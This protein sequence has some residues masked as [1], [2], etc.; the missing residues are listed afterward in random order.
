MYLR[1]DVHHCKINIEMQSYKEDE[2][3]KKE[4]FKRQKNSGL[5]NLL[6]ELKTDNS[7]LY[8]LTAINYFIIYFYFLW[9]QLA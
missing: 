2:K 1:R 7:L 9:T 8:T 3:D 4:T 6:K 5:P